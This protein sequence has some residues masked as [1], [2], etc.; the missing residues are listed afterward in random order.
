VGGGAVSSEEESR[1]QESADKP[2]VQPGADQL[3]TE[4]GRHAC[5]I[6][7]DFAI[8][9]LVVTDHKIGMHTEVDIEWN[10]SAAGGESCDCACGEY[11]QF[12]KGHAIVN[13][14]DW[15]DPLA[16]GAKLEESVWHEDA[17]TSP[18]YHLIPGHR[19]RL[20]AAED[21]FDRKDRLTG[22]HYHG[23]DNPN[24]HGLHPTD[25]LDIDMRFKGQTYDKCQDKYGPIHEWNL[26]FKGFPGQPKA[27]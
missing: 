18:K 20:G 3:S 1:G 6:K 2:T 23:K 13:E 15:S 24:V 17:D 5:V 8:G 4:S 22:C 14:E 19:D 16:W 25:L 11:R 7:E 26:T 9:G 21:V 27:P 10:G 12:V